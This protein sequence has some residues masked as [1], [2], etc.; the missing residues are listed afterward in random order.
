MKIVNVYIIMF[1][2]KGNWKWSRLAIAFLDIEKNNIL[3]IVQF[4]L[5]LYL[6]VID[7]YIFMVPILRT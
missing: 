1:A 2:L 3:K 5:G 4:N 7:I 6:F